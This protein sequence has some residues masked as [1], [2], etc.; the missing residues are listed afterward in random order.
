MKGTESLTCVVLDGKF[1][2]A[3]HAQWDGYPSSRGADILDWLKTRDYNR[4][5]ERV[6]NTFEGE[7][8]SPRSGELGWYSSNLVRIYDTPTPVSV[9]LSIEFAGNSNLCE[10]AYVI[11]L[12]HKTFEVYRGLINKPL[13]ERERFAFLSRPSSYWQPVKFLKRYPF[14]RLPRHHDFLCDFTYIDHLL[15]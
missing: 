11:D 9:Q 6:G 5:V 8:S 1:R 13:D 2:V 15:G 14:N 4:L 3:E 12:D 10:W 7:S